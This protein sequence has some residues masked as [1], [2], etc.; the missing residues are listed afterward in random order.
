MVGGSI[1]QVR[2]EGDKT[3]FWCADRHGDECAV[4]VRTIP[5]VALVH[6][7]DTVWWQAG[8]VYWTPKDSNVR[9]VVCFAKIGN[10]FDPR[11][12]DPS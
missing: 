10:S 7:G 8:Q 5:P 1:I 9:D 6:P 2:R 11:R 4:Y 3:L 12:H